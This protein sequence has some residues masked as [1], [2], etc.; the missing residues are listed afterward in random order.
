MIRKFLNNKE[1]IYS[2]YFWEVENG[3]KDQYTAE[4]EICVLISFC[5]EFTFTKSTYCWFYISLIKN[6]VLQILTSF[7]IVVPNN[8][9][10]CNDQWGDVSQII[11]F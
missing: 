11:Y 4:K 7:Q 5:S 10:V 9:P 8:R 3:E 6:G 1:I 2:V